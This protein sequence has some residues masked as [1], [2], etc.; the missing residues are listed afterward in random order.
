MLHKIYI[1]Y[2]EF[3]EELGVAGS[4]QKQD[5]GKVVKPV[6]REVRMRLRVYYCVC[7]EYNTL[8]KSYNVCGH[9]Q[10]TVCLE[11]GQKKIRDTVQS[12]GMPQLPV[13]RGLIT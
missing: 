2:L 8:W 11:L 9:M 6:H 7:E 3:G 12:R 4:Q 1:S 5:T 13:K 10:Y